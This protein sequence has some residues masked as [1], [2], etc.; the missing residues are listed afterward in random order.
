MAPF[1][2]VATAINAGL[3]TVIL[4]KRSSPV[5]LLSW[6]ACM[7]TI[8]GLQYVL[9][10][11]ESP[12]W[13]TWFIAGAALSGFAWRSASIIVFRRESLGAQVFL[14][15]IIGALAAKAVPV[16]SPLLNA[17]VAYILA[18]LLPITIRFLIMRDE[19]HLPWGLWESDI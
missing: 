4:W 19:I 18:S 6:L 13:E 12:R 11:K 17:Y 5:M 16:L 8:A 9:V 7:L 15:L 2:A 14:A 1:A 3:L 10:Y